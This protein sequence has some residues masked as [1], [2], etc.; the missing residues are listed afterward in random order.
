M[1]GRKAMLAGGGQGRIT[2]KGWL[3]CHLSSREF[4]PE[5]ECSNVQLPGFVCVQ[6]LRHELQPVQRVLVMTA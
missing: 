6:Q 2:V 5:R 4:D 3:A 1:R